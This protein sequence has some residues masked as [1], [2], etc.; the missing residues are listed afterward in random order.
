[1][2]LWQG[3]FFLF[4]NVF[5]KRLHGLENIFQIRHRYSVFDRKGNRETS[6]LILF[7]TTERKAYCSSHFWGVTPGFD[8]VVVKWFAI[9]LFF[10]GTTPFN[11]CLQK[12]YLLVSFT[13]KTFKHRGYVVLK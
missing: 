4:K 2:L 13:E 6:S 9:T 7:S 8:I 12:C 1:M 10:Y 5:M 3:L 11:L